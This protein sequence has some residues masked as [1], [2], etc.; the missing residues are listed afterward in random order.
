MIVILSLILRKNISRM[1]ILINAKMTPSYQILKRNTLIKVWVM[2]GLRN[3]PSNKLNTM[4]RI[5]S[6]VGK[7]EQKTIPN[8][9]LEAKLLNYAKKITDNYFNWKE[10]PNPHKIQS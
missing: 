6:I 8:R 7:E 9:E 2:P 4:N 1:N 5:V 3:I 10:I